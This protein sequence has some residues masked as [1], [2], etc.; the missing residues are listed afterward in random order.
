MNVNNLHEY[1]YKYYLPGNLEKY[2]FLYKSPLVSPH[3]LRGNDGIGL[4]TANS[5]ICPIK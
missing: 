5:P 2:A 4:E 1:R 3:I